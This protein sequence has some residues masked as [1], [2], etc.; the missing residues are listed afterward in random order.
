MSRKH[1]CKKKSLSN[2]SERLKIRGL[3]R[4]PKMLTIDELRRMQISNGGLKQEYI[5]FPGQIGQRPYRSSRN[6]EQL[7][8]RHKS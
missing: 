8:K 4:A 2:Y 1:N 5:K 6:E 3:S 7:L